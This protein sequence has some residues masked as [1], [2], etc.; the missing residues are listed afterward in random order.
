MKTGIV[1]CIMVPFVR[2]CKE[3]KF[4]P[5]FRPKEKMSKQGK[6][7]SFSKETKKRSLKLRGKKKKERKNR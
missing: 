4:L 6:I 5:T 7:K 3:N 2:S 1:K